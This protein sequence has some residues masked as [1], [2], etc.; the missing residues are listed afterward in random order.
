VAI[1]NIMARSLSVSEI[2]GIQLL[3]NEN[4]IR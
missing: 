1:P 3:L 4:Q 2:G